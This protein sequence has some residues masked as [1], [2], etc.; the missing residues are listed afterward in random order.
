MSV[1]E[2][3]PPE[4]D[5]VAAIAGIWAE[6]LNLDAVG[7]DEGFFELGGHSLLAIRVMSRIHQRLGVEVPLTAIFTDPTVA[8]LAA[9]VDELGGP[10]VESSLPSPEVS[11]VEPVLLD[12]DVDLNSL[13]DEIEALSDEEAAALLAQL[14]A[15]EHGP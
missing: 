7:P 11:P 1:V 6:V 3:S 9:V 5:T 14:E 13:L 4:Q 8:G 15:E 12:P 2:S 10:V